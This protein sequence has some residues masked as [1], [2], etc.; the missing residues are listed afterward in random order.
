MTALLPAGRLGILGYNDKTI[1]GGHHP[2][3]WISP[4]AA[5]WHAYV[6]THPY[7]DLLQDPAW[8]EAKSPGWAAHRLVLCDSEGVWLGGVQVLTRQLPR[9]LSRFCYAYAPRGPLLDWSDEALVKVFFE[10]LE[11]QLRKLGA[12]N[13]VIDPAIRREQGQALLASLARQGYR[14]QGFFTDMREIQP[15]FSRW[16]PLPDADPGSAQSLLET[17]QPSADFYKALKQQLARAMHNKLNKAQSQAFR[18]ERQTGSDLATF[19]ELMVETGRRDGIGVRDLAYY[20]KLWAAFNPTD[21]TDFWVL[22]LDRDQQLAQLE[23]RAEK[24]Q[25]EIDQFA[26]KLSR[27]PSDAPAEKRANL[28][29]AQA[30]Q[31]HSLERLRA[32]QVALQAEPRAFIPL[33]CAALFYHQD[34][35]YYLYG[36]SSDH[37]RHLLPVY[38]LFPFCLAWAKQRGASVFDLGGVSGILDPE[39]DPH[40]G[41]LETFKRAWGTE[42]VEYIGEFEKPLR[43]LIAACLKWGVA[44]RKRLRAPKRSKPN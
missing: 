33:A 26:K 32:D 34:H 11:A 27:L 20:Q 13:W 29:A 4:G 22:S 12:V 9:P 18:I 31:A 1:E 36:G 2:M 3:K 7:G 44:L 30:A 37:Y 10:G 43:P 15:R 39:Q 35:T 40:H 14:H 23:T 6:K 19:F 28:E 42:L 5:E 24:V 41:G 16:I 17:S 38:A 25:R 21:A 8:G